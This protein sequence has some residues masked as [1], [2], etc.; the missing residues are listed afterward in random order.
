[1]GGRFTLATHITDHIRVRWRQRVR[2]PPL[3]FRHAGLPVSARPRWPRNRESRD[4]PG[5]SEGL[6]RELPR[7]V[8]HEP[9]NH[10]GPPFSA[11]DG[12]GNLLGPWPWAGS[13]S[14]H[15]PPRVELTISAAPAT[16]PNGLWAGGKGHFSRGP[17]LSTVVYTNSTF[18]TPPAPAKSPSSSAHSRHN[19]T[20]APGAIE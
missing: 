6:T 4:R 20:T 14:P 11:G 2:T 7:M 16:G 9:L 8:P 17:L 18:G 1:M 12:T 13:S 10:A 3:I 15:R 19:R 5:A